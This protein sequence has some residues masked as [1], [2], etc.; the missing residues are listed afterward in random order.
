MTEN[1]IV[2]LISGLVASLSP[3]LIFIATE[4]GR[5]DKLRESQQASYK[6]ATDA[7]NKTLAAHRA[8]YLNGIK[9]VKDGLSNVEK[10]VDQMQ[11]TYKQT[12]AIVDLKIEALE[13]AQ[14]KHNNLIERMYAVEKETALQTEQ[15]EVANHRISDIE[16]QEKRKETK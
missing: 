11:H 15:I 5:K 14:N 4:R 7:I 8:E 6:E 2:A 13:K 10:S 1:I 12:V 16:E 9:E 3:I